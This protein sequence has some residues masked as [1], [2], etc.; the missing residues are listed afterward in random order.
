MR[1]SVSKWI[2]ATALAL[3][4]GS[5]VHAAEVRVEYAIDRKVWKKAARPGQE[6]SFATFSDDACTNAL[7]VATRTADDPTVF[8]DELKRLAPKGA[9]KPP[10]TAVLSTVLD[11][12]AGAPPLYLTVRGT[13]IAAIGGAC[14][15][16]V[17]APATGPAGAQ[18]PFGP[19]G[20]EGPQGPQGAPG[21]DGA[22]GPTGVMGAAGPPGPQGDTGPTGDAGPTGPEGPEGPPSG[23]L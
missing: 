23:A 13:P 5:A 9:A 11:L 21:P 17:G 22:P 1:M 7:D 2:G 8:V 3:C 15:A 18:G 4:A 6:L 14:Q 12:D 19:E 16:Q 10:K 20:N